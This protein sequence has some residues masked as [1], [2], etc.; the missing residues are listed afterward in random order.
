MFKI[1]I[2]VDRLH[3][4]TRHDVAAMPVEKESEEYNM[5]HPRRG[6][7]IIFNHEI[8]NDKDVPAREGSKVDSVKLQETFKLLGFEPE[9]YDDLTADKIKIIINNCK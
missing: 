8:F 9:V 4:R 2:A 6:K 5:S 1:S 3:Y 7:A